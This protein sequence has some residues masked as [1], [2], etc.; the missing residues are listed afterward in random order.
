MIIFTAEYFLGSGHASRRRLPASGYWQDKYFFS[1][2][3]L[4]IS[5]PLCLS[6]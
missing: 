5:L 4:L 2:M 3:A 6:T 1:P